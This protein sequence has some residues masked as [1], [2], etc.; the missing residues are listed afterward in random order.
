MDTN[1]G[2]YFTGNYLYGIS[3]NDT[4]KTSK[5]ITEKIR[6]FLNTVVKKQELLVTK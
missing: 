5:I 3:I 6:K 4:I 1:Y 2:L